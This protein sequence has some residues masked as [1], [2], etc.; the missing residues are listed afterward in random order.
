MGSDSVIK[1]D[2]CGRESG[3]GSGDVGGKLCKAGRYEVEE[4]RRAERGGV[5]QRRRRSGGP[6]KPIMGG[7]AI[8]VTTIAGLALNAT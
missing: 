8:I 7:N 1:G 5:E 2:A 6:G 3:L 4:H